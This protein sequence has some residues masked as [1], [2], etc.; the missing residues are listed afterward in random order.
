MQKATPILTL[1]EKMKCPDP[2]MIKIEFQDTS[3]NPKIFLFHKIKVPKYGDF[4]AD[5]KYV[6][7]YV[8]LILEKVSDY[9]RC[10]LLF[11]GRKCS[12]IRNR[13]IRIF[14]CI[15]FK[16]SGVIG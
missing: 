2:D 12:Y 10:L 3:I 7:Q 9:R 6:K 11:R 5:F 14:A 13:H 16:H 1:F 15:K 4:D 8:I